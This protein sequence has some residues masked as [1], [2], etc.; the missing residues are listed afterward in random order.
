VGL[1]F[2]EGLIATVEV[3]SKL[4]RA[5]LQSALKNCHSVMSVTGHLSSFDPLNKHATTLMKKGITQKQATDA[6]R[7]KLTPRTYVFAFSSDLNAKRMCGIVTDHYNQTNLGRTAF[8]PGLPT[9]IVAR[10][11]MGLLRDE[12]LTVTGSEQDDEDAKAELGADAYAVMGFWDCP[13][14]F[15]W[16]AL[17]L[18]HD[19]TAAL[20][21]RRGELEIPFTIDGYLP[22]TAY[23]QEDLRDRPVELLY[24]TADKPGPTDPDR[25]QPDA[26]PLSSPSVP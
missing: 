14:Q 21:L 17:R 26:P 25:I 10:G 15:G 2:T 18:I 19:V 1:Y 9:A 3:K 5:K 7:W 6:V 24:W 11:V 23:H 22:V 20:G 13:R 4:T 12:W 16:F 8:F